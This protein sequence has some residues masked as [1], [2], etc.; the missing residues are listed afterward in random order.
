MASI[1]YADFF[2]PL[3]QMG[4]PV[5]PWPLSSGVDPLNLAAHLGKDL[6][7]IAEPADRSNRVALG[8]FGPLGDMLW[9]DGG[10][11]GWNG[12]PTTLYIA[13]TT[14][15]STDNDDTPAAAWVPGKLQPFNYGFSLFDGVDPTQRSRPGEGVV[16][17]ADP[18]DELQSLLDFVWDGA[19][20]VLKRG[21]RG[22]P[23]STWET[24]GRF[25]SAG[26][27]PDLDQ[28]QIH[29]R[30]L[31]WQLGGPLHAE[32]YGGTGGLDG[33]ASL[34]GAW[35]PWAFGYCFNVEPVLINAATQIFQAS[36]TSIAAVTHLRHGGVVL[37]VDSDYPT[38]DALAAATVPSGKFSTCL[39]RGLVRP[40]VALQYGIR[41]DIVGDNETAYGHPGPTTR[42]AIARRI[43]TTR[44]VNRLDDN[45]DI[46]ATSFNRVEARHS[47]PVGW[48]FADQI[49]KADALDRVM[50]GILGWWRIRPDG[51]LAVGWV[52]TPTRGAGLALTYGAEG[53]GKPRM[54]GWAPPRA[55]SYV[56]WQTN[57]A[58]QQRTELAPSVD[59][60][61]AALYGQDGCWVASFSPSVAALYPRAGYAR[62]EGGF[63][64]EGD[65]KVECT[66]QQDLL[67]VERCRWQWEL[68]VDP[69]ADFVGLGCTINGVNRLRLG[70]SKPLLIVGL[71]AT[72]GSGVTV[73]FW[74]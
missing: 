15:R 16:G 60:T 2:P 42:A 41:V 65:A 4:G 17:L 11:W 33:D 56:S 31:A 70:E 46:D 72:G 43:A 19:P 50:A 21:A 13:A 53:M 66:R 55:G 3:G 14:G 30:D 5:Q 40:N 68:E 1:E 51:R 32:Y 37:P 10:E 20:I 47:A 36:L 67:C 44:G 57:N 18:D 54:T 58:P 24:V 74:G 39:A 35:K 8:P 7:L 48:H 38:Y 6:L 28:K 12:R 34:R 22:T 23:F 27:L 9:P 71:N 61:S 45:S 62:V 69:L 26:M 49:S 52:D 63:A 59:E 29:L 64:D 73:D 25:S